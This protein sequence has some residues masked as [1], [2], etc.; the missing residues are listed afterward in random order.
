MLLPVDQLR[1]GS[2]TSG[3]AS[4]PH[5]ALKRARS[6]ACWRACM[7]CRMRMRVRTSAAAGLNGNVQSLNRGR[8]WLHLLGDT[9]S[10]RR[11]RFKF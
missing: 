7:V 5:R 8:P 10:Y 1:S 11:P 9:A 2:L 6:I 3:N 4:E